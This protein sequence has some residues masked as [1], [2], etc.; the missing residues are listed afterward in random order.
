ML[1]QVGSR[2]AFIK[3]GYYHLPLRISINPGAI[4]TIEESQQ[5]RYKFLVDFGQLVLEGAGAEN[6]PDQI[7]DENA[8]PG[9]SAGGLLVPEL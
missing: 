2:G 1:P 7:G 6:E 5:R 8:E 3:D 9:A 4:Q